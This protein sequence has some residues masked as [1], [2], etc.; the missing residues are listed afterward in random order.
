MVEQL[1]MV[2]LEEQLLANSFEKVFMGAA[3]TDDGPPVV[4]EVFDVT[5]WAGNASN[6]DI[7]NGIDLSGEGGVVWVKNRT[8]NSTNHRVFD[9][10]NG[11][12]K[13]WNSNREDPQAASANSITAFNNNGFSIT[14]SEAELNANSAN[15]VGWT[16]RKSP[17]FFDVQTWQGNGTAGRTIAH[18]LGVVPGMIIVKLVNRNTNAEGTVYHNSTA[19]WTSGDPEDYYLLISG[20]NNRF[21]DNSSETKWDNTAPT[22]EVFSLGNNFRVNTYY[23][24]LNWTYVGYFFA[25]DTE[26]DGIIKCGSYVGNGNSTGPAVNLGFVPQFL[27][28]KKMD[29]DNKAFAD[30]VVVDTARGFTTTGQNKPLEWNTADDEYG[31]GDYVKLT[32]TGFQLVSTHTDWNANNHYYGY[33]AIKA[34]D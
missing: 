24:S 16:F 18:D 19:V 9:T 34:D 2:S 6:R 22:D 28:I 23:N 3:G 14:G 8:S 30:W 5:L 20:S 27:M 25:H 31:Q 33:L 15:Y 7:N 12:T 29:S 10:K 32:N 26:D 13:S 4:S 11:V 21:E 1:T 17:R